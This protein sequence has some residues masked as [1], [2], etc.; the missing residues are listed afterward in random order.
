MISTRF[1]NYWARLTIATLA[2][3]I[4]TTTCAN[5]PG[6]AA[7]AARMRVVVE[8]LA[9]DDL[10][11]R[12]GEDAIRAGAWV[13]DEFAQLRLKPLFDDSFVQR[14][15]DKDGHTIGTNIAGAIPG[16]DPAASQQ[17]VFITG[18][19][20]HLGTRNGAIFRG[21]N[22]NASAVAMVLEAARYFSNHPPKR[23]MVFAS[24]DLEENMLWGS[25]YFVANP[26]IDLA[27]ISLFTTADMIGRPLG[28][29]P[30]ED[31]FVMGGE[32]AQPLAGIIARQS[33]T[34]AQPVMR[35]GADIV[36]T[37][38]DYGPF[39]DKDIPFL[40]FST[41]ENPDYHTPRDTPGRIDFARAAAITNLVIGISEEVANADARLMWTDEPP[42]DL[43]DAETLLRVCSVVQSEVEAGRMKLGVVEKVL[44]NQ[45]IDR[46]ESIIDRGSMSQ[47]DRVW[48]VRAAQGMLLTLF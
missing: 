18:H 46:T 16:T 47:D 35:L 4:P 34:N 36:G 7:D 17:Y 30:L 24:F 13:A 29:L 44:V 37:R 14:I 45:T 20:D 23:T 11:G 2:L 38:S 27:Q 33:N 1:A 22:D 40:F 43:S 12:A 10:A 21:A 8:H 48:L 5:D 32:T 25:R 9:S 15:P 39:R 31:V 42:S 41:G 6:P 3:L 19:H 26:P 28:D